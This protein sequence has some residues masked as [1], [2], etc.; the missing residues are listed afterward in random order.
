MTD[1]HRLLCTRR[2]RDRLDS[3][4]TRHHPLHQSGSSG[5][6]EALRLGCDLMALVPATLTVAGTSAVNGRDLQ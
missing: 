5:P 6:V 4:T 3:Y 1:R 2:S